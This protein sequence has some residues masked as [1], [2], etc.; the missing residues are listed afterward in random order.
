MKA[1][2]CM[3]DTVMRGKTRDERASIAVFDGTSSFFLAS[4]QMDDKGL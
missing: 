3:L 4:K 2:E 1:K